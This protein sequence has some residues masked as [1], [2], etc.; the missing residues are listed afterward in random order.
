EAEGENKKENNSE[1]KIRKGGE[2]PMRFLIVIVFFFLNF[3]NGMEW[4]TYASTADKFRKAF[5]KSRTEVDLLSMI[6]MILYPIACIPDAYIIDNISVRLGLCI[7]AL[8]MI[9]GSFLKIFTSKSYFFAFLGQAFA[10]SFQPAIVNSPAKIASVWFKDDSRALVTSICCASNSIG[11]LFGYVFHTF[12][13]KEDSEE[14]VYKTEF[15]QFLFWQFILVTVLCMPTLFFM[16][17]KPKIASSNSQVN[18][19]PMALKKNLSLLMNNT[20]F[21]KFLFCSALIVGYF[22]IIGTTLNHYLAVYGLSDSEVT[23]VAGVSNGLGLVAC[24]LISI[25]VDKT[26]KFKRTMLILNI[27]GLIFFIVITVLLEKID[28]YKPIISLIFYTLVFSSI[29]PIY[30]T[31]MD[32]VAELTYP[33]GESYSGGLIMCSNQIV[34]VLGIILVDFMLDNFKDKKY[35]AN[36]LFCV[37]LLGSLISVILINEKL[38]RTEK[39]NSGEENLI[40]EEGD[41]EKSPVIRESKESKE[42]GETEEN[43]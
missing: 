29:I 2:E 16:Q 34:G 39:E 14:D 8:T 27:V 12:F 41:K 35:L 22:N 18:I 36:I 21:L 38:L 15:N 32:Y 20:N 33:V 31:G 1:N 5:N 4:V 28:S 10:S 24:L 19:K 13:I 17:T 43:K 42:E 30:T 3:S 26:K 37:M 6:F 25:V 9:V 40:E 7:A 11:V 23:L